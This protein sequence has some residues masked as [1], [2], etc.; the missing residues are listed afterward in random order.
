MQLL[1]ESHSTSPILKK[2]CSVSQNMKSSTSMALKSE[3][4]S[5]QWPTTKQYKKSTKN[6]TSAY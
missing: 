3:N 6:N 1:D 4:I 2:V 5:K